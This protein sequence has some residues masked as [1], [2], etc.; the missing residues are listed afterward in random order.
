L[1]QKDQDGLTPIMLAAQHK[2]PLVAQKRVLYLLTKAG[3]DSGKLGLGRSKAGATA[4][5]YAA[6]AG[7]TKETIKAL[8]DAGQVALNTF[9][10]QG[11]TPLHW[12]C[13]A[14]TA[15]DFTSTIDALIECG[16][17]VNAQQ[18]TGQNNRIPTPLVLAAAA[19]ND[20]HAKR[21]LQCPDISI[22]TQLPGNVTLFHMAADLN[23]VG[24]LSLLLE[25]LGDNDV[26]KAILL[27][28]NHDGLTPLDLAAQEGH[29]GCVLLLL[30]PTEDGK[31]APT[32]EDAKGYIEDHK[33]TK[34]K[35]TPTTPEEAT[36]KEEP[37]VKT[38][39]ATEDEAQRMAAET[40]SSPDP[41]EEDVQ[42]ALELKAKG[43]GHFSKKEWEPAHD[44]YSQAIA[45]NP[46]EATFYSNRSA[47]CMSMHRPKEALQDA[48]FAR[49][50]RPTWSKA[51]Y[52]M[53][54]ARLELERYED[55]ALSAW[56]GLQQDQDNDELKSLLQK[57]V[58]KGRQDFK[59]G[60]ETSSR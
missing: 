29:V 11:G 58:K 60:K 2:D 52:R 50:L 51:C 30:P 48:V 1:K 42:K 39:D 53:A 21:L 15:K 5:H 57:C 26:D 12:A 3:K 13:A 56:E 59:Q 25:K 14:V 10:L 41:S 32:E 24:T 34:S 47:C 19:G 7:A 40:I 22:D 28:K 9:S 55:A 31:E 20:K 54:V 6:G 33:K 43:N 27:Q 8:Y 16:A 18:T 23:L 46:K 44:F 37:S 45:A 35:T 36:K 4:L 49:A 17:N 38:T